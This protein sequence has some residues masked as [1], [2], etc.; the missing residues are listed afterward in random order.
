MRIFIWTWR[1]IWAVFWA[2]IAVERYKNTW[3]RPWLAHIT[4]ADFILYLVI[5]ALQS[6]YIIT[7]K[8][9]LDIFVLQK[10]INALVTCKI[11]TVLV[12]C[13]QS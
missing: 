1:K 2:P 8:F 10:C 12:I 4:T 3:I 11:E 9:L 7:R 13:F 5:T 6:L